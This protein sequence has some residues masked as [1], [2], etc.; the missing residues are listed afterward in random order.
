MR[1]QP[2]LLVERR[3]LRRRQRPHRRRRPADFPA[4]ARARPPAALEG[5]EHVG[6]KA[7]RGIPLAG[8][9]LSD[10]TR[11]VDQLGAIRQL[12]QVVID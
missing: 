11:S 8:N 5:C 2:P 10:V 9:T 7:C 4:A 1:P 3:P 6:R 12:P